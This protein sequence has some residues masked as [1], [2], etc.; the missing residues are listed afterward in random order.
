MLK[1]LVTYD[2]KWVIKII[3]IYYI[4]AITLGI[5][6]RVMG[7]IFNSQFFDVIANFCKGTSIGVMISG[8]VTLIIR[9]W[10]RTTINMY[11][12]ESYLTHTIPVETNTHYLSK[13]ICAL[14]LLFVSVILLVIDVFILYYNKDFLEILNNFLHVISDS[15]NMSVIG[16]ISLITFVLFVELVFI[17]FCG[18]TGIIYGHSFNNN[19]MLYSIVIGIVIYFAINFITGIGFIISSLFNE[20]LFNGLFKGGSIGANTVKWILL[21]AGICYFIYSVILYI[22]SNK[23][24]NKGLNIE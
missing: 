3:V 12:D 13:I 21:I 2:I 4:L 17:L 8:V 7:E 19:K 20:E 1:K 15:V 16:F 5:I 18:F 10:V 6:G 14:I 23:K 9:I 11:K 24:L 22:V